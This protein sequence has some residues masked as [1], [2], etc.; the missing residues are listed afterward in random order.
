[1][2]IKPPHLEYITSIKSVCQ[3]LDHQEAKELRT[4]IKP[5]LTKAELQTLFQLKKDRT[6]IVLTGDTGVAMVVMDQEGIHR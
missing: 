1:M 4:N 6:R 5:N 2:H 3:K